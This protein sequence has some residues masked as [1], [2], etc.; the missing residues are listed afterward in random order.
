M[1]V[2][3]DVITAAGDYEQA[4]HPTWIDAGV[5]RVVPYACRYAMALGRGITGEKLAVYHVEERRF[6][7]WRSFTETS[8]RNFDTIVVLACDEPRFT[9]GSA[10]DALW[11]VT[12]GLQRRA[13]FEAEARLRRFENGRARTVPPVRKY[14]RAESTF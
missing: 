7:R 12:E 9:D 2:F 8:I 13:R 11:L 1:E 4:P 3:V 5:G 6:L 14:R 10:I